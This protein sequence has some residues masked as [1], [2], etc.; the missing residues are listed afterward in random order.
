LAAAAW[1]RLEGLWDYHAQCKAIESSEWNEIAEL[2]GREATK[3]AA[4]A[5]QAGRLRGNPEAYHA[6]NMLLGLTLAAEAIGPAAN[7]DEIE[8]KLKDQADAQ[9]VA[10]HRER[11]AC[12]ESS[13]ELSSP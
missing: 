5:L 9:D 6:L 1:D 10:V 13:D 8:R 12:A 3:A 7:H 4:N 11:P 2:A